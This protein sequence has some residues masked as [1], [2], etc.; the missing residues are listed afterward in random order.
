MTTKSPKFPE[1]E[2]EIELSGPTGN[3]YFVM[4]KI[5]HELKSAGATETEVTAYVTD[6]MSGDYEHLLAVAAEWVD[7]T[8]Y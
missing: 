3:A 8:T 6:S 2:I 5:E 1:I 7:F 4:G